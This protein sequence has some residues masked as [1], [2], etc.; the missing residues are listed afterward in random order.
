MVEQYLGFKVE[1]NYESKHLSMVFQRLMKC[2]KKRAYSGG[3]MCLMSMVF[4]RHARL[5]SP[6]TRI[7]TARSSGGRFGNDQLSS[8]KPPPG[9]F[10]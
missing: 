2:K 3:N 6:L 8:C 10:L 7:W 5:I 4:G 9:G 1:G